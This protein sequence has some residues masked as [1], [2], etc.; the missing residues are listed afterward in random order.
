MVLYK[1]DFVYEKQKRRHHGA[2]KLAV[3][4]MW[5]FTP[6]LLPIGQSGPPRQYPRKWGAPSRSGVRAF[7]TKHT[8][9]ELHDLVSSNNTLHSSIRE[10]E[11]APPYSK[12]GFHS[13][14]MRNQS[15]STLS[16][17]DGIHCNSGRAFDAPQQRGHLGNGRDDASI[18]RTLNGDRIAKETWR[19]SIKHYDHC[20]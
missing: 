16:T 18:S 2:A 12:Q 1:R 20:I 10:L 19:L 3:R 11:S 6:C 13:S 14:A 9:D 7:P 15:S 17:N 8:K 5:D 4:N